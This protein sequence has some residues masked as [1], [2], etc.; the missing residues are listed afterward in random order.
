MQ[1]SE[2]EDKTSVPANE[3]SLSQS[4][5]PTILLNHHHHHFMD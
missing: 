2:K 1:K 3:Y 4:T 5:I